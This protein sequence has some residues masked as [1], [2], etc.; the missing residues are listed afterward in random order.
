MAAARTRITAASD[1][2]MIAGSELSSL[3]SS[4]PPGV[5]PQECI[6]MDLRLEAMETPVPQPF[7][8]WN[9][10]DLDVSDATMTMPSAPPVSAVSLAAVATRTR[11]RQRLGD[12]VAR[13]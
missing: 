9:G 11:R 8:G 2:A 3:R 12:V 4:G 10:A 5:L 7:F 13:R 6:A 1:D